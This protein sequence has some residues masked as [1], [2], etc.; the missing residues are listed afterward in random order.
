LDTT[1][2]KPVVSAFSHTGEPFPQLMREIVFDK[3]GMS[4]STAKEYGWKGYVPS[5]RPHAHQLT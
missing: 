1:D 4:D 2:L 3:I 5:N